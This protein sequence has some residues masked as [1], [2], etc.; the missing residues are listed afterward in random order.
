MVSDFAFVDA[1]DLAPM[2]D[3]PTLHDIGNA[4]AACDLTFDTMKAAGVDMPRVS[5]WIGLLFVRLV[6]ATALWQPQNIPDAPALADM[7]EEELRTLVS[8]LDA[9]VAQ[10][11]DMRGYSRLTLTEERAAVVAELERREEAAQ[12]RPSM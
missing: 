2:R 9:N 6:S 3:L 8:L 12:P 7:T 11:G 4:Q 10:W 1:A 5:R